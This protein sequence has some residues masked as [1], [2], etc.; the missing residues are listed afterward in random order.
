MKF[1]IKKIYIILFLLTILLVGSKLFAKESKI[2]YTKE[3]ISSYFSGIISVNQSYNNEAFKYLKKAKSLKNMHSRFNAEYIR[4]LI[5][6]EKFEQAFAFS[7]SV[8]TNDE[9]IF[10]TDLLLGLDYFI[11]KDY[12]NAETHFKRL[13]KISQYNLFF[14]DFIGNVL[15]AWSK[16]SQ[17]NK[18]DSFKFLEKVPK[19]YQQIKKTQNIFLQC[20]FDDPQTLNSFEEL[21]RDKDYNFSRYNFFLANYL[22]FNN[23]TEEAKKVI[24]NSRKEYNSNLLIKQ[25]ENFFLNN[26][27]E[28]IKNIFNCK[29]SNDSL[30]EFFYVIANLYSSEKDYKLS[31]FYMKL[32][33]FL[34]DKFL[35]NQI[36]LAE[37]YYYQKKKELSKNIY[38]SLKSI[39][40]VYSWYASRSIAVILLDLKGKK[41]S[42]SSLE[43]EFNLLTNPNFEHYYELA[44]F[45]K[46]NEYYGKSIKYYSL[47]LNEI[48]KDHSLVP[49]ILDRRGTSFERIG[50]WEN[51][52]KDLIKSLEILPDQAHVLNYLAYSWIDQGIKVEEG[53]EMLKKAD[54]LRANDGYIID[55]LGWAYYVKKNYTEAEF[56]LQRAVELLPSD[57]IINDHYADTLWMLNKNIQARYVWKYVLKLDRAEQK[58]KDTISKKLIF[59]I[60]KKL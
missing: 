51:A 37:N 11:N 19:P 47:A 57:P 24:R 8:W 30:A 16:A 9:F 36:L 39:G 55:S 52:E 13:N 7:K 2:R 48:K 1:F 46:D 35:P 56:F 3:N 12:V 27:N 33:I 54:Q 23:K 41:Y 5:L 17:G 44:N 53:L 40:P 26:K 34:N 49:K 60:T 32:S 21:I 50:D 20:Y 4:T 29:N 28:K 25:T 18:E 14:N 6:I 45:Y 22:L 38:Q 59:G 31:N 10:E 43:N 15:I 42:V 58:L